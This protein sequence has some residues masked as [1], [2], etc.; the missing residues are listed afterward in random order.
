MRTTTITELYRFTR[1]QL[2][3]LQSQI[4]AELAALPGD[5]PDREIALENLR[6]IRS[7]LLRR[8]PAP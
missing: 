6:L 3:A 2:L 5:A 7:L 1:A 8:T 4:L